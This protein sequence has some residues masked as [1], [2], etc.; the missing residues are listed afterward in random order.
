M[1]TIIN[2][3]K[4]DGHKLHKLQEAN[5]TADSLFHYFAARGRI[6]GFTDIKRVQMDLTRA[7]FNIVEKDALAF[8]DELQKCGYGKMVYSR[9]AGGRPR[10]IWKV[11]MR[12]LANAAISQTDI[13][14]EPLKDSLM[15]ECDASRLRKKQNTSY[16]V[17]LLVQRE[18][19]EQ[20]RQMHE[21]AHGTRAVVKLA[22][23]KPSQLP[24]IN[25]TN[26]M[27]QMVINGEIY[28]KIDPKELEQINKFREM[29]KLMNFK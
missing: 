11:D 2:Q 15:R 10:F 9:Q 13:Y 22:E 18:I 24:A 20:Q 26:S 16:P 23:S 25:S 12:T 6:R 5:P 17:S 19:Q 27:D 4:I 8:F 7:K 14:V 29:M 1:N 21:E 28:V 3:L